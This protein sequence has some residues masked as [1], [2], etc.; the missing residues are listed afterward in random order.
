MI[1]T[2]SRVA[3]ISILY[4]GSFSRFTHGRYTPTYYKY[5]IDRAPDGE[6]MAYLPFLDSTL[7]T[8]LLFS[9]TRPLSAFIVVA[10]QGIGVLMRLHEKKPVT[11]DAATLLI[12]ITAF[13][14][15]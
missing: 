5:Q 10:F 6:M 7:G 2:I 8:L 13:W 14:T 1:G 15:S 4:L 12:A 3:L 11:L 9:L